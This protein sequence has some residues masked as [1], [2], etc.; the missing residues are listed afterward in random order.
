MRLKMQ[1]AEEGKPNDSV[2]FMLAPEMPM[3]MPE[4]MRKRLLEP[5]E[6]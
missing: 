1:R 2:A 4:W 5:S 6:S 3:P